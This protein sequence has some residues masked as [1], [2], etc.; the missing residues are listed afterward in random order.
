MGTDEKQKLPVAHT[1]YTNN[2]GLEA[3]FHAPVL[4][5]VLCTTNIVILVA[6]L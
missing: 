6:M 3:P 1:C 5:V 2:T 4:T